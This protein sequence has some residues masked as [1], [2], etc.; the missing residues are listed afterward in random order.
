MTGSETVLLSLA[1]RSLTEHLAEVR[2]VKVRVLVRQS[3]PLRL[4]P[5][6]EGVHG[7]TDPLFAVHAQSARWL[8]VWV[9]VRV[10]LV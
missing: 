1:G 4:R 6:H 3:L 2:V 7:T 10:V 5:H 9:G 8:Q